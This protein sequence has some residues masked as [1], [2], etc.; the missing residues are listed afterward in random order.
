[1]NENNN[2]TPERLAK[3]G[4]AVSEF[5]VEDEDG[6]KTGRRVLRLSDSDILNH[7]ASRKVIDTFQHASGE[8]YYKDWY[9]AG[10]AAS[11]VVDPS[12]DIVDTSNTDPMV[13]HRM[14]ALQTWSKTTIAIGPV[15]AHPLASMLLFDMP[16]TVYAMRYLRQRNYKTARLVAYTALGL[17]LDAL[18]LYYLGPTKTRTRYHRDKGARPTIPD[19]PT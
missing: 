17:A 4:E 8:R 15:H 16:A 14:E 10:L 12:R 13:L 2:P 11:G 3:A 18:V 19:T 6:K 9:D 1:M 7:L 5:E